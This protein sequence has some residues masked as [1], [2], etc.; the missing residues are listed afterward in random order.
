MKKAEIKDGLSAFG[1]YLSAGI[2]EEGRERGLSVKSTTILSLSTGRMPHSIFVLQQFCIEISARKYSSHTYRV[3]FYLFGLSQYENYV[4]IDIKT[5]S[6]SL[7]VAE[8]SV[9]RAT[10]DLQKD[11]ILIKMSHPS[12]K[13]RKEYF[14]NPMAAWR[15]KT[16]NR[17]KA[18]K[19]FGQNNKQLDLWGQD[20][21]L[22]IKSPESPIKRISDP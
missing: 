9:L 19:K 20:L 2:E 1:E 10:K 3:L 18:I 7:G 22:G 13:R 11:N 4:S 17:V 14:I 15:G 8:R 21:F 16:L 6:E 5:I 12:D